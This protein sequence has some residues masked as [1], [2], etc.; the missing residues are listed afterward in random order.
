MIPANG[1]L[2]GGVRLQPK[3]VLLV[4]T[5][6]WADWE[7]S[8]AIAEVN[9]VPEYVVRTIAVDRN[10]KTSI[11]GICAGIDY[12]VAEY[13]VGNTLAMVILPG[14]FSWKESRHDEIA[15][16]LRKVES[17]NIP[18]AAICG[19]TIF[20]GKHGFLNNRKHTGDELDLFRSEQGYDGKEFYV[21]A[22]LVTD[23]GFITANETA[24]VEFA[25]E[26]FR[27]LRIGSDDEIEKWYD[28]FKHGV[29]R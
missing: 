22:Q 24:S 6:R 28:H 4:L 3:E 18:I 27:M 7:A 21:P 5:D 26:I 25:R 12:T 10:P 20:L 8:F 2:Y 9:S 17:M 13:P 11:G 16:F 15:G 1:N 14:G 19:A 23:K 29:F